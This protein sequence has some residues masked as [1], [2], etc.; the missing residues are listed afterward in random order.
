MQVGDPIKALCASY[1]EA[2]NHALPGVRYR[3]RSPR[4]SEEEVRERRPRDDEV[5]VYHFPQT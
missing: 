3:S 1:F 5:Q 2:I 4:S